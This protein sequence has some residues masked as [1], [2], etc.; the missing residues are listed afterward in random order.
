M[1]KILNTEENLNKYYPIFIKIK[2]KK[3]IVIGGGNVAERKIN[4]LVTDGAD[5]IVI[6]PNVTDNLLQLVQAKKITW[7]NRL[8]QA[9]DL[10]GALLAFAATDNRKVNQLIASEAKKHKVLLNSIDCQGE[11]DFIVPSRIE[12]GPLQICI[13]TSGASPALAKQIRQD[14]EEKFCDEYIV[15]LD[16][17]RELREWLLI[18]E[19][20]EEKRQHIFRA[21]INS[22]V[23]ELLKANKIAD[24]KIII[25]N[26][27]KNNNS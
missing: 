8:F 16:W 19:P 10:H 17:M 18:N 23:L 1:N 6:A 4:S 21:V 26:Y 15:F 22:P 2:G 27:K 9:G 12:R 24:A 20:N 11:C 14:L 7:Y 5:V 3:C 25:E 13:S